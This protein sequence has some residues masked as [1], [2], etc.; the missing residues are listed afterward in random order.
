MDVYF[1]KGMLRI[2]I[3]K[4]SNDEGFSQFI[5]DFK[6]EI[7]Y[8]VSLEKKLIVLRSLKRMP[9]IQVLLMIHYQI[10]PKIF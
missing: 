1:K 2:N 6:K 9:F 8:E 4:D 5:Y 10:F 3:I 7:S